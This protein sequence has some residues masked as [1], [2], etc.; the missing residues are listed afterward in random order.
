MFRI[1]P[2]KERGKKHNVENSQPEGK[3]IK[4]K[5]SW[6]LK[7]GLGRETCK[8]RS[9]T[10]CSNFYFK[11]KNNFFESQEKGKKKPPIEKVL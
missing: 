4:K 6:K 9:K 11:K 2:K 10:I 1:K 5:K 7:I 3:K 8:I